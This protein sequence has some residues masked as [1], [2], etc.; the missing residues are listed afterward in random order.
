MTTLFG[1]LLTLWRICASGCDYPSLPAA[2]TAYG[3]GTIVPGD[4][5]E[6]KCNEDFTNSSV[7]WPWVSNPKGL[8]TTIRTSCYQQLPPAGVRVDKTLHRRLMPHLYPSNSSTAI[9]TVGGHQSAI[10]NVNTSTNTITLA[11]S[12]GITNGAGIACRLGTTQDINKTPIGS[13]PGAMVENQEYIISSASGASFV[14]TLNGSA[15]TLNTSGSGVYCAPTR[16]GGYVRFQGINFEQA[17]GTPFL[18]SLLQWGTTEEAAVAG[19][20]T[21]VEMEH[22]IVDSPIDEEGPRNLMSINGR[23]MVVRDS[24][25]GNAKQYSSESHAIVMVQTPGPVLIEN[26]YLNAASINILTGG[27]DTFIRGQKVTDLTIRRNHFQKYG[28]MLWDN[29]TT[30]PSGSCLNGAYFLRAPTRPNVVTVTQAGTPGSTTYTYQVVATNGGSGSPKRLGYANVT[31]TG[32]ATLNGTNYNIVKFALPD[33]TISNF[34][35]YR[36]FGG[37]SQGLIA[38]VSSWSTVDCGDGNPCVL[39]NDQGASGDG[40]QPADPTCADGG[41]YTC[42]AGSWALD[43]AAPYRHST[44]L[45]KGFFESKKCLRCRIE[46]NFQDTGFS[47]RGDQ[48][49]PGYCFF[50]SSYSSDTNREWVY[51]N[52]HCER[53]WASIGAAVSYAATAGASGNVLIENN[54]L[55]D[56]GIYPAYTNALT[57]DS[58]GLPHRRAFYFGS[59]YDNVTVR[60]TTVRAGSGMTIT[61]GMLWSNPSAGPNQNFQFYDNILPMGANGTSYDTTG[62]D[63]CSAGGLLGQFVAT[64]AGRFLNNV[65]YGSSS[66]TPSCAF[67]NLGTPTTVDFASSTD[68]TLQDISP[69]SPNCASGCAGWVGTNGRAPGVDVIE[70]DWRTATRVAGTPEWLTEGWSLDIGSTKTA[71]SYV[72]PSSAACTVKLFTNFARTTLST[73]TDSGGEQADDRAGNYSSGRQ[74]IFVFNTAASTNYWGTVACGTQIRPFNFTTKAAGTGTRTFVKTFS[75]SVSGEYSSSPAFT[76]PTSTSGTAHTIVAAP[77]AFYRQGGQV[78]VYVAQ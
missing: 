72:A 18:Y 63:D 16:V 35:I 66:V 40:V 29:R 41:C 42:Q 4:I 3:S 34:K 55:S 51:R 67:T 39:Y 52:N 33:G 14:P 10:T 57:G 61:A 6:M 50:L 5:L 17:V 28:Y 8:M 71:L 78:T 2:V 62:A 20:P 38:T 68:N 30:A 53:T 43:S 19:T 11:S 75:S 60:N 44:Y 54:N 45:T 59:S 74:R 1:V 15:V 49:N 69:Y 36:L 77:V 26:N 25:L 70:N 37:A 65:F 46:D 48:G 76:S 22:S 24:W 27:E 73:D 56:I 7:E 47:D 13:M 21:N 58:G 64:P 12:T 31:G 23:N 9:F 32:A